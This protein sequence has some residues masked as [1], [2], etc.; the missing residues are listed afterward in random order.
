[1]VSLVHHHE[2]TVYTEYKNNKNGK[3]ASLHVQSMF[4]FQAFCHPQI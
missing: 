4:K 3:S 1:M 2:L